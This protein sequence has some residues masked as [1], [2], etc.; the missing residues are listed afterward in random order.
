MRDDWRL[1]IVMLAAAAFAV[2]VAGCS[3]GIFHTRPTPAPDMAASSVPTAHPALMVERAETIQSPATIGF[4]ARPE[5]ADLHF[6]PGQVS[7]TSADQRALDVVVRWLKEHPDALL[8]VEG[9]TDDRG[10]RDAN[11]I[12]G[13]KR[14]ASVERYLAAQGIDADRMSVLSAGSDHPACDQK[15]DTCR[16][17]NR[18]ACFL[19][20]QP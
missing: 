14:A 1:G 12:V 17:K 15:T 9:H 2:A 4:K 16:A 20:R 3:G 7:L 6:R 10:D 8:I 11:L 5:L 19:V 18:R 13:E